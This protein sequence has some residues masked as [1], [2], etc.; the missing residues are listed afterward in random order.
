MYSGKFTGQGSNRYHKSTESEARS[1]GPSEVPSASSDQATVFEYWWLLTQPEAWDR[2]HSS[3]PEFERPML[4]ILNQLKAGRPASMLMAAIWNAR[5]ADW[6]EDEAQRLSLAWT[7]RSDNLDRYAGA[8]EAQPYLGTLQWAKVERLSVWAKRARVK[9][10]DVSE[11]EF[12]LGRL[13]AGLMQGKEIKSDV[14]R[15]IASQITHAQDVAQAEPCPRCIL[16]WLEKNLGQ[17]GN[18]PGPGHG[19]TR[20][21]LE[22]MFTLM[23]D[24]ERENDAREAEM[25]R[26]AGMA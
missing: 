22:V 18:G 9:G 4:L 14:L 5:L 21:E 19:K 17:I 23:A 11:I 3:K 25:A 1:S 12:R 7:M 20:E 2:K 8:W 16:E 13:R 24:A 26:E 10:G 6:P 15:E